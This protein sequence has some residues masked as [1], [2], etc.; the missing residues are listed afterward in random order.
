M[1][2]SGKSAARVAAKYSDGLITFLSPSQAGSVLQTFDAAAR[3]AGKDSKSQ[4]K[5]AEFKVSYADD[6][7]E[8]TK[9]AGFWRAT[10]I[11]NIF[12]SKITDP[13]ILEE[14][15][16]REVS[17]KKL[18][19]AIQITTSVEDCIGSIERYFDAGFTR[20]HV[21][22]TSP[23]EIKFLRDFCKDVLPYFDDKSRNE[24]AISGVAA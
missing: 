19:E 7:D 12:T 15:A 1:A 8:A 2:A 6:Y 18:R 4:Q 16:K 3:S 21:H 24:R 14:K 10:L 11:E 22:S 9:S 20:V 5:I 23:D 13:R 17:D